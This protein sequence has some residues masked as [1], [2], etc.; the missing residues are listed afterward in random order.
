MFYSFCHI[1]LL[2]LIFK[3]NSGLLSIMQLFYINPF[4]G[5]ISIVSPNDL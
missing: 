2:S 3:Y 4:K 1:L 5:L